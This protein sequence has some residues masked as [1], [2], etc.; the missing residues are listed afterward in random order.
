[1]LILFTIAWLI[2]L[3]L[4]IIKNMRNRR[5]HV[6]ICMMLPTT[7]FKK[8]EMRIKSLHISNLII[9]KIDI[10]I[11]IYFRKLENKYVK[12]LDPCK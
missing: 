9:S 7:R 11:A 5:I 8:N 10:S 6:S 3:L 2:L 4:K 12:H 1:M